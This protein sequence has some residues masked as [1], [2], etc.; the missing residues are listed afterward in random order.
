MMPAS[1]N[2][3]HYSK[4]RQGGTHEEITVIRYFR[5]QNIQRR[6]IR[7]DDDIM[8]MSMSTEEIVFDP[9]DESANYPKW[10]Y[11]ERDNA[12]VIDIA[13]H[14]F[15]TE[16]LCFVKEEKALFINGTLSE[17]TRSEL[18]SRIHI[19]PPTMVIR[20]FSFKWFD[21]PDFLDHEKIRTVMENGIFRVIIPFTEWYTEHL[22]EEERTDILN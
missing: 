14:G 1:Y 5:E 12:H 3:V 4:T 7:M 17:E 19:D 11:Y 2:R 8:K 13:V 20:D 6:A 21:I 10:A 9:L 18:S 16:E 15:S 22:K